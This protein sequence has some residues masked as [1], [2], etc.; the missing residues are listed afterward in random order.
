[1]LSAVTLWYSGVGPAGAYGVLI[2]LVKNVDVGAWTI[3]GTGVKGAHTAPTMFGEMSD[4][5][6]VA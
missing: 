6:S 1:M 4:A 2:E 3:L 5:H